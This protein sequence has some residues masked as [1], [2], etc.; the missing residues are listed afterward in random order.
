[1]ADDDNPH[2]MQGITAPKGLDGVL[3]LRCKCGWKITTLGVTAA[4]REHAD[5][6]DRERA[7]IGEE[8][9]VN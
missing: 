6:V 7:R 8:A 4:L 3:E 5:H 9:Q 1:M 2:L